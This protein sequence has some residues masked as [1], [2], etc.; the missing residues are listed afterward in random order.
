MDRQRPATA[1]PDPE[2][3]ARARAGSLSVQL[4]G[5]DVELFKRIQSWFPPGTV[6]ATRIARLCI[7]AGLAQ[8]EREFAQAAERYAASSATVTKPEER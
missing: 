5:S 3:P 4:Q 2:K 6:T 7:R 1:L 8:V